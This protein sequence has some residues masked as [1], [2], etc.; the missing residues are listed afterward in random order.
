[1]S[2]RFETPAPGTALRDLPA[3]LA[4]HAT[5]DGGA[6]V[7]DALAMLATGRLDVLLVVHGGAAHVLTRGDLERVLPSPATALARHEI[8]ELLGRVAVRHALR[9]PARAIAAGAPLREAV[10]AL[11]AAGW[12]P[13]V[14]IDGPRA[15]GVLT[16][17][18]L[19]GAIT[20]GTSPSIDTD[21]AAGTD[22]DADVRAEAPLAGAR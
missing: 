18:S 6:S 9:T 8:P 2:S 14:V 10:Q 15:I 20:R 17:E 4:R 19:L 16:A 22:A 5:V 7:H 1:M 11:R 21:T 12:R 13:L 3:A